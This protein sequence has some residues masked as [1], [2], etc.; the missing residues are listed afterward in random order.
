MG[1]EE[2]LKGHKPTENEDGDGFTVIKGTY[3]CRLVKLAKGQTKNEPRRPRYEMEFKIIETVDGDPAD[4]RKFFFS[5][6]SEDDEA[7]KKFLNDL[8]TAGITLPNDS[9]DDFEGAFPLVLDHVAT[10][11][12]WG[13]TPETK[14]DGTP[15]P[16]EERVAQQ[17]KKIVNAS[18]AKSKAKP[19]EVPF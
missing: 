12:A 4:G 5:Y 1:F 14:K 9:I 15:I 7:L 10:I 2:V 11:R 3:K 18:K 19:S 16:V 13:W 17:Q 8:F 6:L